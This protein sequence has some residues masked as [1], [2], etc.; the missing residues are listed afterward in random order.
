MRFGTLFLDLKIILLLEQN[1]SLETKWMNL[2]RLRNKASLVAQ[3]YSQEGVDFD[4]TYAPV[5][6]L[7]LL[8]Y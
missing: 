7:E 4:E 2:E 5:A 6:R 3:D 1:R 8:E